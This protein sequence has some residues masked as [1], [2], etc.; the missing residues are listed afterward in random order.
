MTLPENA[1]LPRYI[2]GSFK[3]RKSTTWDK[4]LYFLSEGRRSEDS[5]VLKSPTAS[6]GFEPANLGTKGQHATPRPPKP[7]DIQLT[8]KWILITYATIRIFSTNTE[9]NSKFYAPVAWHEAS[10]YGWPI[11][12]VWHERHCLFAEAEIMLKIS[13]VTLQSSVTRVT[14]RTGFVHRWPMPKQNLDKNFVPC[15]VKVLRNT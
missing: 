11:I 7:L 6:A 5:F 4:R 10:S 12:L 2:Q 13:R 8:F 9:V 15:H 14:R 3:C 1:R